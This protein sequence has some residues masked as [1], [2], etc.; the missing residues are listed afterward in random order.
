MYQLLNISFGSAFTAN[1]SN[2]T[3]VKFNENKLSVLKRIDE[4]NLIYCKYL[5]LGYSSI[6]HLE[7]TYLEALVVLIL[8]NCNI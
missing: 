3:Q 1:L 8:T 2:A 4:R 5:N 6:M 7:T